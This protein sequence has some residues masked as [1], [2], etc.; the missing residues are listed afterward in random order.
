VV[1]APGVGPVR[2][3]EHRGTAYTGPGP[4]L[5]GPGFIQERLEVALVSVTPGPSATAVAGH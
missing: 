5:D 2:L 4:G 3:I 1:Y